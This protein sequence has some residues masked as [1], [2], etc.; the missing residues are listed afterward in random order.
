MGLF[1]EVLGGL[2][3]EAGQHAALYEEVASL[4]TQ[5]GGVN[6]LIQK[7]EQQGLGPLMSSWMGGATNTPISADQIVRVIG[8]DK[9]TAIAAKVGL[10]EQQVADGI[11]KLLP[12]VVSHL[13]PNGAAPSPGGSQLEAEG[14]SLLKSKLF[15]A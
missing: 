1:N 6:G 10:S 4:V 2:E 11:S 3:A 14:L 5:S 15:G 8:Q 13:T 9:I 7:F 12:L